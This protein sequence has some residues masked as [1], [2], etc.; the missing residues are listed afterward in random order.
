[1]TTSSLGTRR[2]RSVFVLCLIAG[3]VTLMLGVSASE[4]FGSEISVLFTGQPTDKAIWLLI[5]GAIATAGGLIGL[6]RG[7]R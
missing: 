7:S 1:M 5:G 4:S 2:Y 3:I 6:A